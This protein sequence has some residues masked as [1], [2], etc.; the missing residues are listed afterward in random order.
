MSRAGRAGEIRAFINY[1][2]HLNAAPGFYFSKW[3]DINKIEC[4]TLFIKC[5]LR[6][7]SLFHHNHSSLALFELFLQEV[8]AKKA[9]KTS[10][11]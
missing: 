9:A 7:I 5:E 4:Q 8:Q 10:K 11:M 3:I 1:R 6:V 2:I